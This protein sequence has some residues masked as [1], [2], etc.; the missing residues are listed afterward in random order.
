MCLTKR[1][2]GIVALSIAVIN[3]T[4]KLQPSRLTE[5]RVRNISPNPKVDVLLAHTY[6]SASLPECCLI[7]FVLHLADV[8]PLFWCFQLREKIGAL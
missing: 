1:C 6:S 4:K 5:A 2:A 3:L 7:Y 8:G